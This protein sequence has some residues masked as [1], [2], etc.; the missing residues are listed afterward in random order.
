MS[1]Q[2]VIMSV[3]VRVAVVIVGLQLFAALGLG[4]QSDSESES[5]S[6]SVLP[7]SES[8]VDEVRISRLLDM[9]KRDH[10]KVYS[11]SA[12]EA[13][14]RKIFTQHVLYHDGIAAR[15]N[16]D[17]VDTDACG[18]HTRYSGWADRTESEKTQHTGHSVTG[19]HNVDPGAVANSVVN[20]SARVRR[21]FD[22]WKVEHKRTYTSANDE[23]WRQQIFAQHVQ[24]HDNIA[25]AANL[26]QPDMDECGRSERFSGWADMTN[27][28]EDSHTGGSPGAGIIGLAGPRISSGLAEWHWRLPSQIA[29]F[30]L[31]LF[32]GTPPLAVD[33]RGHVPRVVSS[34]QDQ[35]RLSYSWIIKRWGTSGT[36]I[37]MRSIAGHLQRLLFCNEWCD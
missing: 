33:W 14:R 30:L 29:G 20:I 8:R 36:S 27:A 12:E 4:G 22:L 13:F 9:W 6:A 7:E 2:R 23:A 32:A 10:K 15:S 31:T 17:S 26:A 28:E 21:L 5:E 1:E 35:V 25:A 16:L 24:Y 19:M 3:T 37:Q 18:R 11:S 34:A